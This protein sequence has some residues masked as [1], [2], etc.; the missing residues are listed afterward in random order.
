MPSKQE[1][2]ATLNSLLDSIETLPQN[3]RFDSIVSELVQ[4]DDNDSVEEVLEETNPEQCL[5]T[6]EE[7]TNERIVRPIDD[8]QDIEDMEVNIYSRDEDSDE[9]DAYDEDFMIEDAEDCQVI[10]DIPHTNTEFRSEQQ[11]KESDDDIEIIED[12]LIED[13]VD[14]KSDQNKEVID[15][16]DDEEDCVIINDSFSIKV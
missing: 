8:I 15:L 6:I 13:S 10:E 11:N 1:V 2:S 4:I 14:N 16:S 9:F 7:S 3:S 12:S 5:P